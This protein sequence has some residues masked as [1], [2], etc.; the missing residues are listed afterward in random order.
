MTRRTRLTLAAVAVLAAIALGVGSGGGL[1]TTGSSSSGSSGI[2]SRSRTIDPA[3]NDALARTGRSARLPFTTAPADDEGRDVTLSGT[4]LDVR[5]G[6]PVPGVEVVFRND[7]GEETVLADRAGRYKITVARGAYR[8]F[9]RD[10]FVLSVG[11]PELSRLPSL[12]SADV[13]GVPDEGLMPIIVA[14]RDADAVDLG[15]VRG[16]TITG[17]VTDLRGAPIAGA[18]VRARGGTVRPALGTDVAETDATGRFELHLPAGGYALE[19]THA[20]YA[21]VRGTVEQ[22]LL[23]AGAKRTSALT[24]TAGCVIAGRVV[25]AHGKP[26]SD[27]AI[28]KRWGV[29]D[30]EFGPTGRVEADGTFRWV[31]TDELDVTLRAWPWKSP[32]SPSRTFSCRDGA[33]FTDVVFQLADRTPDIEGTLVDEH[34]APVAFAFVDLAPQGPGGI[35]QQERTDAEGHWQVFN[36]PAGPYRIAAS[37]PGHGITTSAIVAPVHDVALQLGGV[38]RIAGTTTLLANGTFELSEVACADS[39]R[40]RGGIPLTQQH[41]LVQ[42]SGGHF[43]IDDVP[44]CTIW[45]SA[46]WHDQHVRIDV[47]VPP[48]GT[49]SLELDLGPPHAK[50][51]HG[52]VRDDAG[53]PVPHVL[54]SAAYK[55]ERNAMISTDDAGRFRLQTYSGATLTVE[56]AGGSAMASVGMANVEDEEVDLTL[57]TVERPRTWDE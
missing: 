30:L 11:R 7:S 46:T 40:G 19:A 28:E 50:A 54:V 53:R 9:V 37:A 36:M 56:A 17:Q 14:S 21:G 23:P 29:T 31:T 15:V 1:G 33:R 5:T 48:G 4:V 44:A 42:V 35:G 10:E 24:L 52:T 25:D 45:A 20:R 6:E 16:G 13:A 43:T 38:G 22:I 18:V 3:L 34:G 47:E 51:V 39:M 57:G 49:G 32:P 55:A 26:A 27:G 8:A 41:R 12:P 2:S